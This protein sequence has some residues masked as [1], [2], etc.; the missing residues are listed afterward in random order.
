MLFKRSRSKQNSSME[1]KHVTLYQTR[2]SMLSAV[3]NVCTCLSRRK[4]TKFDSIPSSGACQTT[5]PP[6]TLSH[7]EMLLPLLR[8]IF[9]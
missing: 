1:M 9:V 7:G 3:K 8:R 2:K 5:G 6:T 4:E